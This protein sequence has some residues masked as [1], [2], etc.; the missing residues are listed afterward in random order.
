MNGVS[1]EVSG[2][3]HDKRWKL[4]AGNFAIAG[5][6]QCAKGFLKEVSVEIY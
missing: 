2:T 3:N 6:L 4:E 1:I 5:F